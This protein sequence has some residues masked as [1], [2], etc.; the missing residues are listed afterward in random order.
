MPPKKLVRVVMCMKGCGDVGIAEMQYLCLDCH[1]KDAVLS[2]NTREPR[3]TPVRSIEKPH[4][5]SPQEQW[6]SFQAATREIG[7]LVVVEGEI[8]NFTKRVN[9]TRMADLRLQQYMAASSAGEEVDRAVW[10]QNQ[11]SFDRS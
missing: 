2:K 4:K 11:R 7:G 8:D 9:E 1:T 5:L 10:R 6:C 3:T